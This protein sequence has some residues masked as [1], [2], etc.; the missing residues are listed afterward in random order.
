MLKKLFL[1]F[2]LSGCAAAL[3][4]AQ[5][6]GVIA[7]W[8]CVPSMMQN[9]REKTLR[10]EHG[11]S[12]MKNYKRDAYGLITGDK[13][14][15]RLEDPGNAKIL[16]MLKDSADKDNLHVVVTGDIDGNTLKVKIISLL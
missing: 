15:F 16:Q 1:T 12:L 2:L 3:S 4:A 8:N 6:Q 5:L 9:G 10:D 11:C 13:K 7:D 14:Y